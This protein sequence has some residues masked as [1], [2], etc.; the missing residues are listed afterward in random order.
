MCL[1]EA[2]KSGKILIDSDMTLLDNGIEA[3]G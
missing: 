3:S 1:F 2:A